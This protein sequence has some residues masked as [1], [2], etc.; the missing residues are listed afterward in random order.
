VSPRVRVDFDPMLGL[1]VVARDGYFWFAVYHSYH[2]VRLR[3]A[4]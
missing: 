1:V 2:P 4:A 3:W